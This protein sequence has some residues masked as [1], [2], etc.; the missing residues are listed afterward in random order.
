MRFSAQPIAQAATPDLLALF[1]R[2][3][4]GEVECSIGQ[5][6]RDFGHLWAAQFSSWFITLGPGHS[7]ELSDL[8]R[9][10]A[11]AM[12]WIS[13]QPAAELPTLEWKTYGHHLSADLEQHLAELGLTADN[14][15]TLM[16]GP[17]HTLASQPATVA[18]VTI[19]QVVAGD[20]LAADCAQITTLLEGIFGPNS[21]PSTK[22]LEVKAVEPQG[23]LYVADYAGEIVA[24]GRVILDGNSSWAG[25]RGGCVA[26]HHRGRGLYRALVAARAEWAIQHG[27]HTMRSDCTKMSQPI[28][29][30]AG[31]QALT[32]T[33]PYLGKLGDAQQNLTNLV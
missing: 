13:T 27:A 26:E 19:R 14:E 33:T 18:G 23:A 28:L 32:S 17:A 1:D 10:T 2:D 5:H 29:E 15:E 9:D 12:S 25:L 30:R 3:L 22:S 4:R 11:S 16:A 21:G 6:V 20:Q 8:R 31:L 7:L 24:T